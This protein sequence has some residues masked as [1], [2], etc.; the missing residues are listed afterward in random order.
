MNANHL[1][2]TT[3]EN[4]RPSFIKKVIHHKGA[5]IGLFII[6]FFL[7]TA[8]FAPFFVQ[9]DPGTIYGDA[10]KIPPAWSSLGQSTFFLGTD[11]IGRDIFSRL[12]YG[13]R[14]SIFIGFFV[15]FLSLTLGT[16]LGLISGFFG[17]KI[18]RVIMRVID[19][20]MSFPSILLAIVVVTLLGPG[21][22]NAVFA[23]S[24][25]SI[26]GFTRIVRS[27]VLVEKE[28]EYVSASEAFGAS[29]FRTLFLEI[30]PN[31]LAPLIVQGSL[32]FS[33]AILNAA[34]LSFL[35]L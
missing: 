18:D 32:T 5:S 27:T 12:I 19:V 3:I 30:F 13:S 25:V 21:I 22:K 35:G 28:K 24:I 17:G 34:A 33:D 14:I 1:E 15:V 16:F 8:L 31:C 7:I 26:P 6:S 29:P 4:Y 10:L 11:D 2:N 20:I 9:H 23:V